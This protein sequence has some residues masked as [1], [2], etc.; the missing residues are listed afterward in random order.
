MR[1]H[2]SASCWVLLAVTLTA[3]TAVPPNLDAVALTAVTAVPPRLDGVFLSLG[4]DNQNFTVAQWG[5][6][7]GAMRDV[8]I[9][10]A[11]VRAALAGAS[12][13]TEGGCTLGT[14][15]AYYPT[16]L[17]PAGCFRVETGLDDGETPLG[18]LLAG[19]AQH[20][21]KVHVTPAMPHTPFAWPHSPVPEYFGYL[22]TLE[23]DAFED[24]LAAFPQHAGT[25][26][27][28]YTALEEWNG[29]SW[30]PHNESIARQY[31]QPLSARVRAGRPHL[32]VWA[33]PYYVGNATLHPTALTPAAFAAFW[34]RVWELAPDFGW[35]ALQDA[36]GW[37]GNSDAEVAAALEALRGA[38]NA[39]GRPLWSNVELFEG[40]PVGC[41]YP[42]R[43]GRHPAPMARVRAQLAN[44]EAATG[45]RHVAWEWSTCL[46]PFTNADTARLYGEYR[47]YVGDV[48]ATRAV[49]LPPTPVVQK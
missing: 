31:L 38:A 26:A 15:T 16:T 46:S 41:T 34:L 29:P 40:W 23:A 12:N 9:T 11:V 24:V 8:G 28:V 10:F 36:R 44:E 19:A 3:V 2:L 42:T 14:Y 43:C 17:T 32:Q 7:F 6:E 25:I 1:T 18:R 21:L 27:G 5:A 33:S 39:S 30:A 13:A 37:Q 4:S 35:I 48:S 47:A 20:Q 45:G 22:A 49:A